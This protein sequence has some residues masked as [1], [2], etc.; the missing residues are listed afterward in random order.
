MVGRMSVIMK[1][2]LELDD[3]LEFTEHENWV[4]KK[5]R[6]TNMLQELLPLKLHWK[7]D[8]RKM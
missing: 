2:C 8:C 4:R 3:G 5:A 1:N 6:Y 7:T